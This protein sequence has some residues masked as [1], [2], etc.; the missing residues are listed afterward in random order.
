[1]RSRDDHPTSSATVRRWCVGTAHV[2]V[3]FGIALE[4]CA[5]FPIAAVGAAAL[6]TG[7]RAITRGTEYTAGGTASR[8][9][10]NPIDDVHRAVLETFA[11][12]SVRVERDDASD[13]MRG[14]SLARRNTGR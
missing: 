4:G 6:N 5:V 2:S 12:T 10:S 8:T 9:F 3:A 11:R 14:G 13:D 7:G 1:M